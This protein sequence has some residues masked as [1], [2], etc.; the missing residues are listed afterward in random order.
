MDAHTVQELKDELTK[1]EDASEAIKKLL[2]LYE[3]TVEDA[4]AST[5]VKVEV[6]PPSQ[7]ANFARDRKAI[8]EAIEK[9]LYLDQPKKKSDLI[10]VLVRKKLLEGTARDGQYLSKLLPNIPT[11]KKVH[12]QMWALAE[13]DPKSAS[14]NGLAA[15]L[16]G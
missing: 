11:I 13:Y 2:S 6:Q 9:S 3:P 14:Q 8:V 15:V 16:E 5:L 7:P 12:S 1:L 4:P 10:T